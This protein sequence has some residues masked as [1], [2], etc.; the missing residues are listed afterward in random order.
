MRI[1]PN[2]HVIVG[3]NYLPSPNADARPAEC[4]LD[5]IVI[6]NI[7]LPPGE[8]GQGYVQQ[9]FTNTLDEN[10]HPYFAEIK[11]L[12]VSSHLLIERSGKLT[13]FVPFDQRAWHAGESSFQ[14]RECC[15][16]FSIGIE[17]EGAD[18][19]DYTDA[20]Y[21]VLSATIISLQMIYPTL[22]TSNIVGHCDI[23]P[24]RKTDPGLS[25]DWDRLHSQLRV[26][27]L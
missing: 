27:S 21:R 24:D 26:N 9:L 12:C 25:F 14:G 4:G 3:V 16:D 2:S 13:Q 23:A 22:A 18:D 19:V 1:D 20:Q 10:I 6:H 8:F 5:L 17:L 7:S 15:N 11:D